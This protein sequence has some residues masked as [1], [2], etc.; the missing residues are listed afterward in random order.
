MTGSEMD[1]DDDRLEDFF[2]AARRSAPAP[3]EALV[4]RILADAEAAMPKAATAGPAPGQRRGGLAAWLPTFG[5]WGGLATAAL[6][7]LWFGYAGLTDPAAVAAGLIGPGAADE[8]MQILP[9]GET[10]ALLAGWG[11]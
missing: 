7:G 10:V 5:G 8:T 3:S 1:R 11:N 6:A 9:G 4:A 2:A